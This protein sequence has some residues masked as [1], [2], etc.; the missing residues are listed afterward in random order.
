MRLSSKAFQRVL[1][2]LGLAPGLSDTRFKVWAFGFWVQGLGF[3]LGFRFRVS[4][5]GLVLG[6]RVQYL[7]LGFR[8]WTSGFRVWG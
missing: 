5:S 6:F 4:V 2:C 1:W 8:G 3:G 7:G